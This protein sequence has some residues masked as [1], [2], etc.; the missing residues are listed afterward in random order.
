M[1]QTLEK[2]MTDVYSSV[3]DTPVFDSATPASVSR[4]GLSLETTEDEDNFCETLR[5]PL[6]LRTMA[7]TSDGPTTDSEPRLGLLILVSCLSH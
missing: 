4:N 6:C 7:A 1:D 5:D 3:L 2:N